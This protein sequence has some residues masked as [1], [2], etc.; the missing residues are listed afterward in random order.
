MNRLKIFCA[1][2]A[3]VG[4]LSASASAEILA[5]GSSVAG[6]TIGEWTGE[7]WNWAH[8]FGAG[9]NPLVDAGGILATENQTAPV[10]FVGGTVGGKPIRTYDVPDDK[11]LLIPLVAANY[12]LSG[13]E[14]PLW[15]RDQVRQVIDDT[16]SLNFSLDGVPVPQ[17]DLFTHREES[18]FFTD[19]IAPGNYSGDPSG[20]WADS[21]ADG[22]WL[23]LEPLSAGVHQ[24]RFG[25][26][27][28][29]PILSFSVHG[30]DDINVVP[31]PSTLLLLSMAGV[32]LFACAWR[33]R[34]R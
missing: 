29:S 8:S 34:R 30:A 13:G 20:A 24:I 1:V 23:M 10:F 16:A 18:G 12:A 3:T 14:D 32:G 7:W 31:E 26:N 11:Y 4:L 2:L 6:K 17:V 27:V 21:F 28:P 22:Y 9:E 19:V 33:R 15:A 5:P 25:G